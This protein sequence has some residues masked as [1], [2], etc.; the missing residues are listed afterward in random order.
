MLRSTRSWGVWQLGGE[1]E[2]PEAARALGWVEEGRCSGKSVLSAVFSPKGETGRERETAVPLQRVKFGREDA[3]EPEHARA[4]R[5]LPPAVADE[6]VLDSGGDAGV[7]I[8]DP[9][10][11]VSRISC[12]TH[13]NVLKKGPS[14]CVSSIWLYGLQSV[15]NDGF[16]DI[17][18]VVLECWVF[19]C[20]VH[21]LWHANCEEDLM[22]AFNLYVFNR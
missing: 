18:R 16:C 10:I 20:T 5:E 17:L 1:T 3:A 14:N 22:I 15:L 4:L 12:K 21:I 13:A 2:T 6:R 11:S 8:G 9:L 19:Y 7:P